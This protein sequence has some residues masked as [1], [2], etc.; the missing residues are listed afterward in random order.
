MVVSPGSSGE[1][2]TPAVGYMAN[3]VRTQG[4]YHRLTEA[5]AGKG[6]VPRT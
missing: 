1:T 3:S 6:V 4:D 5:L 2:T